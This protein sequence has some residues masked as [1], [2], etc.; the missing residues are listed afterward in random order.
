MRVRLDQASINELLRGPS[1]PVVKQVGTYSRQVAN[2]A[3]QNVGVDTGRLRSSIQHTVEVRGTKVVG[4]VGS[5]VDY[6]RYHHD[7]TGIYGPAGRPIT[8][9]NGQFLVFPGKGGGMVFAKQVQGSRPNP[10]LVLALEEVVPWPVQ[11]AREG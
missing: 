10:F 9:R 11:R 2:V 7:G 3:K 6:A 8:P 4:R 1:G 5:L